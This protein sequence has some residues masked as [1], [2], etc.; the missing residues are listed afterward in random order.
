[1]AMP[2]IFNLVVDMAYEHVY[3]IL[4]LP[5]TLHILVLAKK[6]SGLCTVFVQFYISIDF[7]H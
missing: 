2:A 6:R 1:M 3:E 7:L 4:L 5:F